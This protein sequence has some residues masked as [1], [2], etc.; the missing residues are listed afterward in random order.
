MSPAIVG[1]P[2]LNAKATRPIAVS[3]DVPVTELRLAAGS[4]GAVYSAASR[5]C[6]RQVVVADPG[7]DAVAAALQMLGIDVRV[8]QLV[9]GSWLSTG[10][11]RKKAPSI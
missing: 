8:F 11:M 4:E 5:I 10:E 9:S 7:I 6:P 3:R 1:P 2:I